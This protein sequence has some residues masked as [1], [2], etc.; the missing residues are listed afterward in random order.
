MEKLWVIAVNQAQR[1][2]ERRIKCKDFKE[3]HLGGAH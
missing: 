2:F 1:Q 3:E